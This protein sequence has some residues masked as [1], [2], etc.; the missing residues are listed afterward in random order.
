MEALSLISKTVLHLALFAASLWDIRQRKLPI[1]FMALLFA[2]GLVMQL[3]IGELSIWE[4]ALGILTGGLLTGVSFI[5]KQAI[6]LGDALMFVASGAFLGLINNLWLMLLSFSLAAVCSVVLIILRK[7]RWKS[8][9][10]FM[11]FMFTAHIVLQLLY[12]L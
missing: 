9:I 2:T 7:A 5:S 11:P 10:P 12:C 1:A 6:G 4:I 3:V 8:S